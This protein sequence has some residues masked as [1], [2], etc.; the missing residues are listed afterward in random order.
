MSSCLKKKEK[1]VHTTRFLNY[2]ESCKKLLINDPVS[3]YSDFK[4]PFEVTTDASN[5]APG[6]ISPQNS[7]PICQTSRTL[8]QHG[9]N[10]FTIEKELLGI[11]WLVQNFRLYI[12]ERKFTIYTDHRPLQWLFNLKDPS[13]KLV[14][15]KLKL[16][17]YDYEIKYKPGTI[18]KVS[19]KN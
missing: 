18:N 15:W 10:Y 16:S 17:E 4:Q 8:N 6:A 5:S 13:S 1:I 12:F 14:R 7:K 2:F 11:V 9:I 19:R 3:Q